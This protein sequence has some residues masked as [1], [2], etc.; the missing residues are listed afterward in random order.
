[1]SFAQSIQAGWTQ[2]CNLATTGVTKAGEFYATYAPVVKAKA[3]AMATLFHTNVTTV[4]VS[5]STALV[6]PLGV[7]GPCVWLLPLAVSG[8]ASMRLQKMSNSADNLCA[9][10]ALK[11]AAVAFSIVAGSA[12]AVFVGSFLG[13]ATT[14]GAAAVYGTFAAVVLIT[15]LLEV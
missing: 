15:S 11:V 4:A 3:V 5:Q 10:V 1:M 13:V 14:L 6:A 8:F 7:A 9:K 12:A 2:F